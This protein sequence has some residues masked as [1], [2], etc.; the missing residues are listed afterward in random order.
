[1]KSEVNRFSIKKSYGS[2]GYERIVPW[3]VNKMIPALSVGVIYG[4]SQSYKTF[5]LVDLACRIATGMTYA[6]G[7]TKSG[8]VFFI[9]AEGGNGIPKRIRAWEKVNASNIGRRIVVIPHA[10]SP[11]VKEQRDTL[12][13]IIQEESKAQKEAVALIIFDTFSQCNNGIAENDAGQVSA[14]MNHCKIITSI[15]GGTVINVHHT[16]RNTDEFR[17]SSTLE[18]NVDFMIAVKK[19]VKSEEKLTQINLHKM[20]E[21]L[22]DYCWMLKLDEVEIDV[23]DANGAALST[24]CV[25]SNNEHSAARNLESKPQS[26]TS[27][28]LKD[29]ECIIEYLKGQIGNSAPLKKMKSEMT[30]NFG[31]SRSSAM[32]LDRAKKYLESRREIECKKSGREV[33]IYLTKQGVSQTAI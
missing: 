16:K 33:I 28:Y 26:E 11:N 9:A 29:A 7:Q 18:C 17:G 15:V 19:K 24:L 20:K 13:S 2:E 1:M 32:R 21:G 23:V 27:Q 12:I 25:S 14:Y 22:T 30:L 4:Q 3:L 8:I 5:F 31:D 10:V 6:D